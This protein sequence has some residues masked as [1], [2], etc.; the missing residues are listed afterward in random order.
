MRKAIYILFGLIV[1]PSCVKDFESDTSPAEGNLVQLIAHFEN[2]PHEGESRAVVTSQGLVSWNNKDRIS[3]YTSKNL[4][5]TFDCIGIEGNT[6]TFSALLDR[7]EEP[8]E[9]AVFPASSFKSLTDG[10]AVVAYASEYDYEE[11]LMLAPMVSFVD[12]DALSF[13]QIGG[14]VRVFCDKVPSDAAAFYLVAEGRRITGAFDVIPGENMEVKAEQAVEGNKVKVSFPIGTASLAFN[15][16]VPTGKYPRISARFVDAS[17]NT[18]LEWKILTDVEILRADMY[19]REEPAMSLVINGTGIIEGN[20][21]YGLVS[22][23]STGKGIPDVPVTDG[24]KHTVTD[25]N[26]VYQFVADSRTRAIY[27]SIPA[28]YEVPVSAVDGQPAFW[29]N[30]NSRNDFVLTPRAGDWTEFNILGIS[31]VHFYVLSKTEFEERDIYRRTALPDMNEYLS[32]LGN[33]IAINTGDITSNHTRALADARA[34]F[35]LI[36]KNGVTVPMF[37][38]IGN[39]DHSNDPSCNS[40]YECSADYVNVFGPTEYS[41][42]I[43][44]AHIVFL[45]NIIYAGHQDGGYGKAMMCDFGITDEN[46]KWLQEDLAF[47]Q[48]KHDKILILCLHAPIFNNSHQHYGDL[49]N[50]LKTFGEAHIFSGHDHHNIRREFADGWKGLN[51][52]VP[53]E[54][55]M[56]PLGNYWLNNYTTAGVPNGYHIFKISGAT[57]SEQH[58]KATGKPESDCQFRVYDSSDEY[59]APISQVEK[60]GELLVDADGKIFFDWDWEFANEDFDKDRGVIVRVFDAGTRALDCKVWFTQNGVRNEMKRVVNSHRDQWSFFWL[61]YNGWQKNDFLNAYHRG[62]RY[63]NYWYYELPSGTLAQQ[64]NWKVEVELNGRLFES[65]EITR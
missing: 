64:T 52:K 13:K 37:N 4:I 49:R 60:G 53:E 56:L 29:K 10:I 20:T 27:P 16:P 59:H 54:H 19:V 14:M 23:S 39:H 42:N 18:L 35:S 51:G 31:D 26:G 62:R 63:Q 46:Y 9:L 24:Y 36:K 38:A 48:D 21:H 22:D 47:V 25:A 61:W 44:K 30:G 28:G 50:I 11:D 6:A 7:D 45:N 55:N 12:G 8:E 57:M 65:S 41:I 2:S 58:F 5:R 1:L 43:G 32:A 33:V 15:V 40:T 17:D 34:E 3:V